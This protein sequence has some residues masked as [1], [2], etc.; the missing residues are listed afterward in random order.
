MES[1][2][3]FKLQIFKYALIIAVI[4]GVGS[5][6]FLGVSLPYL[7]G[8]VFGTCVAVAGFNIL[9]FMSERLVARRKAWLAPVGYFIR[10]PMYGIAFY[11]CYMGYG[12]ISGVACIL[13]IMTVQLAII[14]IHGIKAK[15]SKGKKKDGSDEAEG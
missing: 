10:L 15:L 8:L 14:Y 1:L 6:P 2:T 4:F 3:A 7:Y 13:G 11:L 12:L 9:V 5:L